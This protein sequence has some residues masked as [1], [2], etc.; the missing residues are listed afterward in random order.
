MA[1]DQSV[2]VLELELNKN[3]DRSTLL[4]HK[5]CPFLLFVSADLDGEEMTLPLVKFLHLY[6][7][8]AFSFTPI[9]HSSAQ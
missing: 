4:C 8:T 1:S 7:I 5:K 3:I 2:K 9:N 6:Y